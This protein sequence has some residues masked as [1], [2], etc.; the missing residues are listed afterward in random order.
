VAAAVE[1]QDPRAAVLAVASGRPGAL[2][3]RPGREGGGAVMVILGLDAAAE[4]EAGRFS[5]RPRGLSDGVS[6][7]VEA[8]LNRRAHRFEAK[9]R[10]AMRKRDH[11]NR[12][13]REATSAPH[14]APE[15]DARPDAAGG[16]TEART[17]P[18]VRMI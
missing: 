6:R 16:D 9:H 11:A 10:E 3:W 15:A 18:E 12:L 17:A 2:A 1:E 7:R 4:A 13:A 5:C 14:G 8:A